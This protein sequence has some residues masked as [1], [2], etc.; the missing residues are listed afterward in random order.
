MNKKQVQQRVLQDGN[1]LPLDK[2]EWDE[3]TNTFSSNEDNL[4]LDFQG[5]DYCTF[6]TGSDCTF[7]T[8]FNCTFDTGSDCTFDTGSYCTFK[9]GSDCT[10]D[11]GCDCTFDTGCD[12]IFKTRSDCT[13]KTEEECV[14]VRRDIY[15]VIEIPAHTKIK[16]NEYRVKG[17]QIIDDT[18]IGKKVKI[19][20]ADG[21]ILEGEI[22][23]D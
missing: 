10:F 4:V 12:C 1:P 21:Q 7:D 6:K 22:V 15:E 20:V 13:F 8:G 11:T 16:L 9:T 3:K 5:I 2:F 14:I 17:Y 18:P 19:K 23:E